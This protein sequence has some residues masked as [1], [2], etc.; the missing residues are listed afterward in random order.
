[1]AK[2]IAIVGASSN[3]SKFANKA[4][5]AYLEAGYDVYPIHP[6]EMV[7]EDQTVYHSI[8]EIPITELDRVAVY[9]PPEIG[10]EALESFTAKPIG[11]VY[12]NPGADAP[13]VI[14]KA[15]NLGLNVVA[16]CAI[17]AVGAR[18]SQFPDE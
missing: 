15:K 17:I 18:P 7:V 16:E 13:E 14:E 2:T 8:A 5:R 12:L 3:R 6:S 11:M 10:L 1:M 9:L 4:V